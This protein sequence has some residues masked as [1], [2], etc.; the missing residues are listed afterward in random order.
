MITL[1]RVHKGRV[2]FR[3]VPQAQIPTDLQRLIKRVGYILGVLPRPDQRFKDE[4]LRIPF[5]IAMK[6]FLGKQSTLWRVPVK[7]IFQGGFVTQWI[8]RAWFR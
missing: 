8:F 1:Q 2:S 5:D 7:Q 4:L 3:R 6:F